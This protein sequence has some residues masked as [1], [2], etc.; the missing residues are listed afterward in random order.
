M[1]KDASR[2]ANP[3]PE[4]TLPIAAGLIFSGVCAYGFLLLAARA[5]PN[6]SNL[7][8]LQLW[9]LTFAFAPGFFLP[10]EQETAR[11]VS[12]RRALGQGGFAVIK[13]S[14]T[15]G[16]GICAVLVSLLVIFSKRIADAAFHGNRALSWALVLAVITYAAMHLGRGVLSG[17]GHFV[18]YGIA[19]GGDG[20][21]RILICAV[22]LVVGVTTSGPFGI[23]VG[24]PPAVALL[25]AFRGR[26]DVLEEGPPAAWAEVTSNLGWL[27]LGSVGSAF[28]VNAGP[29]VANLLAT[30]DDK[31]VSA[32]YSVGVDEAIWKSKVAAFNLGVLIA[33]IPLFL[34][35]A[36]VAALLPKLARVA[37]QGDFVEFR[38]GFRRLIRIV[39]VV[40]VVGAVG[41]YF[42][43][44]ALLRIFFK[45]R[46]GGDDLA[47]L[48]IGAGVYMLALAMAQALIALRGHA[49]VAL[50]WLTGVLALIATLPI[51]DDLMRRVEIALIAS[52]VASLA[53]FA[54]ALWSKLRSGATIDADSVVEALHDIP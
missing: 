47:L 48:A 45:A 33:R 6:S 25:L 50:G 36:V 13:R 44:P 54:V 24:L 31:T 52:P 27:L 17:S 11:A 38:S 51:S 4:G 8:V 26:K 41:G 32:A 49:L 3:L 21:V 9:F 46:L 34:F 53:V 5:L 15:M 39:M 30:A 23:A 1:P 29:I 43:G 22:L 42:V 7:D 40:V 16:A 20:A 19:L 10:L 35:Q 18:S 37:A 2:R 28:I 12:H 14:A